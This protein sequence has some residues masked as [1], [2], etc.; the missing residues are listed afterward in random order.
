MGEKETATN[1]APGSRGISSP[2][3]GASDRQEGVI[4]DEDPSMGERKADS[5]ATPADRFTV[6]N[7]GG[8]TTGT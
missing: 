1:A 5:A 7:P 8:T 3:G 6:S 4:S 2:T